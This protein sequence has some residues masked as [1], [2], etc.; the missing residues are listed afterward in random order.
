MKRAHLVLFAL[1]GC[2]TGYRSPE[3]SKD[4]R[5]DLD[6]RTIE[7][8]VRIALGENPETADEL[9][10]VYCAD[11]V[12]YLRGSVSRAAAAD[13]AKSIAAGVDGVRKVVDRVNRPSANG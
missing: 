5:R 6:D 13:R 8:R 7:S 2:S 4:L 3:D 10:E 11:A 1:V 9:I 12:I